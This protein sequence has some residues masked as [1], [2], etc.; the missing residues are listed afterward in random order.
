MEEYAGA[1]ETT[2]SQ[3]T[4]SII[5]VITPSDLSSPH[6]LIPAAEAAKAGWQSA[7]KCSSV[8]QARADQIL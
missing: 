3:N 8:P 5:P 4:D 6:F 7:T 2:T 1:L